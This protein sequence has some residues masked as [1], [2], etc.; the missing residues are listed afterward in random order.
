MHVMESEFIAEVIDPAAATT[1]DEGREG[2]LVLTNLGR[3][4]SPLIRYRTGDR[5][6]TLSSSR[7]WRG[8]V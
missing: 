3:W 8:P 7:T 2:E 1:A 5:V 4:G 6:R